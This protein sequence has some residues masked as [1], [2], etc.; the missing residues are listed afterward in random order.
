VTISDGNEALARLVSILNRHD[1]AYMLVGSYSSNAYGIPR[2]T[3]DAD[4][5]VAELDATFALIES[6]LGEDYRAE[7]QLEFELITG[8][9]RRVIRFVPIHFVLEIF[10]LSDDTFDQSRFNR[11]VQVQS[12]VLGEAVWL[13]TP[14]DVII[15]KLRWSR[16]QDL[17]DVENV[18]IVQLESLDWNY[19]HRWTDLHGTTNTLSQI[20]G[21][22]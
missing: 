7:S 15:Q 3:K 13:P 6:S 8:T 1:I 20:R 10:Q 22:L 21:D 11:R 4:L 5:V 9:I 19:I 16:P 17:L 14:E 18:V 2:A 12:S